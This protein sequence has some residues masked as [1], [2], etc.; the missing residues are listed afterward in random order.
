MITISPASLATSVPSPIAKPTSARLSAGA[1]L[2]PSPVIPTTIPSDCARRTMRLLS[3]GNA[4]AI[5]RSDGRSFLIS[6]SESFDSSLLVIIP[7]PFDSPMSLAIAAAVSRLSPVIITTCIPAR[8]TSRIAA[9]TS[10]LMSSRIPRSATSVSPDSGASGSGS[11][12]ALATAISRIALADNSAR[13]FSIRLLSSGAVPPFSV[14]RRL[15][16]AIIF[17]GAPE[18]SIS[19]SFPIIRTA[20]YLYLLSNGILPCLV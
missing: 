11:V 2:I 13:F 14:I 1:S 15:Q 7:S 10:R 18:T 8:V 19:S 16:A 12:S 6:S 20:E 5:T 9:G 4:R 3:L 17:S